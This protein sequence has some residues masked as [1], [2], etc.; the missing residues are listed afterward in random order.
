MSDEAIPA[1][2]QIRSR[3]S[4]GVRLAQL[5]GAGY[6]ATTPDG[7][8]FD[9]TTQEV[10]HKEPQREEP[11]EE[12]EKPESETDEH[13]SVT[14]ETAAAVSSEKDDA[15]DRLESYISRLRRS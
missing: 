11:K 3:F 9:V 13:S 5:H 6:G 10:E 4:E 8:T 7:S 1:D 15:L 2:D 12:E 14:E